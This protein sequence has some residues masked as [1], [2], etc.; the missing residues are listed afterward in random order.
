MDSNQIVLTPDQIAGAFKIRASKSFDICAGS[1]GLTDKQQIAY[2]TLL[3]RKNDPTA[4]SLTA[5]MIADLAILKDKKDNPE[6]PQGAKTYCEEWLKEFNWKRGKDIKSKYLDKGNVQEENGFTIMAVERGLGMVYK[7]T[8][9]HSNDYCHGT[10]DIFCKNIV[11]DNKCSWDLSTFPMYKKELPDEKYEWQ[12]NVYMDLR[13]TPK[14]DIT[15][16]YVC[17]TLVDADILSIEKEIRWLN[18]PNEIYEKI[19]KMVYTAEY[20]NA[21]IDQ[22][23]PLATLD[24]FV[25]IP[26]SLRIK[27][28]KITKDPIK[29]AILKQRVAMCREYIKT[30]LN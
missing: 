30:L 4:K 11:Y 26:Q 3:A 24:H 10:D 16:G 27:A 21:C 28:F 22:F 14:L 8:Q 1:I 5:N 19:N 23:C 18:T 6:L 20:F 29:I 15:E 13:S 7:N 25:E 2:D 12:L 9:Y 17:Y